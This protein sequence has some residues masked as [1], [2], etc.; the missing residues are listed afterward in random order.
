MT[1]HDIAQ[2][3]DEIGD[4]LDILG[5]NS[6]KVRAYHNAARNVESLSGDIKTLVA[7]NRLHDLKGIG[8][9][10]T[11][12]IT[13]LV[14]TGQLRYYN[15]LKS[16]IPPGLLELLRIPNL[17]P[18][19][20]KA[21]YYN[22]NITNIGELEYACNENSLVEL[23]GFGK[24]SQK[25][26][27]TGVKYAK[28]SQGLYLLSESLQKAESIVTTL[29]EIPEVNRINIAGSIRRGKETVGD[30]DILVSSDNSSPIMEAFVNLPEVKD[31]IAHGTTKSSVV[32]STGQNADL[33]VV[34]DIQFPYALHHFTG[35]KEHNVAM[36]SRAQKIGFKM[37]EYGLFK[38]TGKKELMVE[39]KDEADIFKKLKLAYIDPELRENQGEIEAAEKNDLPDLIKANDIIG[40]IHCHS[41][42]SDGS[43]SIPDLVETA[44][45]SGYKY[46]GITDH[47]KS[48][49]YAGGLQEEDIIAQHKEID[50]ISKKYTGIIILKGIECDILKDGTLD[51]DDSVL[52]GFD[53]VI[54]SIHSHFNLSEKEQTERIINAMKN[55][56]LS[57]LGHPTG[58]LLLSREAYPINMGL[59][60]EAAA[61]YNVIIE[62]NANPHRLDLDWRFCRQAKKLGIKFI[63]G[64]D[65][66]HLEMLTDIQYGISTA[67][68]GWLTKNDILNTLDANQFLKAMQR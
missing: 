28:Q 38:E 56:H 50:M 57:I 67:R 13:E 68:K 40:I 43:A 35:S 14:T 46:I 16:S 9:A 31:I 53:F 27:L 7:E 29:K 49:F 22:L 23:P 48:A 33:R 30:I 17:G 3:L 26:I 4:I 8:D 64:V 51:Y 44:Q 21:L 61:K 58:R 54:G 63:I 37:N 65:A 41:V 32:L 2:I 24:K 19:K 60:L 62:I 18:K 15:E 5:D 36:R 12:K 20:V 66:H 34:T 52:A 1:N 55:K 6:F 10:L 39:C 25:K 42:W 11:Q 59:V 45:N 47:S